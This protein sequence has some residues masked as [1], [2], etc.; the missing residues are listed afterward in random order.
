MR[1][2]NPRLTRENEGPPV[3]EYELHHIRSAELIRRAEHER[4][5]REAV[6]SRRA[7]RRQA[8]ERSAEGVGE[9]ESHTWRSRRHRR[10]R[11]A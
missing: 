10:P 1:R 8:G 7:T 4:L 6:R 3:Y 11:A 5:V 9:A 2:Q